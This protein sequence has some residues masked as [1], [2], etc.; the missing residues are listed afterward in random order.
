VAQ[1]PNNPNPGADTGQPGLFGAAA[2]AI[3]PSSSIEL[4]VKG[5]AKPIHDA[6]K[7]VI[8]TLAGNLVKFLWNS[9]S[10]MLT[11]SATLPRVEDS[12]TTVV[13]SS[14]Q[15]T[16]NTALAWYIHRDDPANIGLIAMN[17]ANLATGGSINLPAGPWSTGPCF[18]EP[19]VA[20]GKVWVAYSGGVAVF[21]R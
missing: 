9:N 17:P 15:Q 16:A 21:R 14:N 11:R 20:D 18:N 5:G 1:G 8:N 19:M 7:V 6:N 10:R 12:Q 13:V 4:Y 2:L 3:G